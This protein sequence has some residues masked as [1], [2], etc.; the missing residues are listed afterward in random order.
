MARSAENIA[1]SFTLIKT[2]ASGSNSLYPLTVSQKWCW[3][4]HCNC[5][6]ICTSGLSMGSTRL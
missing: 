6:T 2:F 4:D 3:Y 5:F 1:S